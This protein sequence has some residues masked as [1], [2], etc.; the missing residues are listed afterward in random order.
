MTRWGFVMG[1]CFW[2]RR[3]TI[4]INPSVCI[5]VDIQQR[6]N[7]SWANFLADDIFEW[8]F[9]ICCIGSLF[10]Y[11]GC[12]THCCP[13]LL[14]AVYIWNLQFSVIGILS[15]FVDILVYPIKYQRFFFLSSIPVVLAT[16]FICVVLLSGYG[17]CVKMMGVCVSLK[18]C[19]RFGMNAGW[20]CTGRV[21][22]GAHGPR[23]Q[24]ILYNYKGS[25]S[26]MCQGGFAFVTFMHVLLR[27]I[28]RI[29]RDYAFI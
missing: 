21:G 16:L 9:L 10:A 19:V 17:H 8:Q 5:G 27:E 12:P 2:L 3:S 29:K 7:Q 22:G 15:R 1:V 13:P 11:L 4:Y 6:R 14:F 24:N 23:G 18:L 26:C 20:S 25:D 28:S